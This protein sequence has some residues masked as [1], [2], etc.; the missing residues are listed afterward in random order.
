[1]I[2]GQSD[3]HLDEKEVK[4]LNILTDRVKKLR[5]EWEDA[6]PVVCPED[7][8]LFTKSW[9][10]TE[11]MPVDLRWAQAFKKRL[12]ESPVVIRDGELIVSSLT[13]HI[14][15][16]NLIAAFKPEQVLEMLED[17]R[18]ARTMS[19]TASAAID[20]TD[21]QLLKE[22]AKYWVEHMPPD[23]I[24]DKLR[25]ELGENHTEL[26]IDKGGILEG[27]FLKATQERGLF[28]DCGAW[29]GILCLHSPVID[30]GLNAIIE[31]ANAEM[32]KM[33]HEG[34]ISSTDASRKY[35]LLQSVVISCQAIIDWAKRYAELARTMAKKE[36]NTVR[37]K[38]L[39]KIAEI[40]DW[41]PANPP[42]SFWEAVQSVRF[43]HLAIRKEQPLRPENSVGRLDQILNRYYEKDFKNG[44]ISRQEAAELLGC[45]WLKIREV[46][47]LQTQPPKTRIAP[48]SNLPDVTIGGRDEH[49]RD[50]TNELSWIILEVMRQMKLSEPAVYIRY[51][52]GLSDEFLIYAL[53]CNRDLQ[54]GIPA[55]LNDEL[56]SARY[57][58]RG[59]APKDA[60]DWAASGCL[61]YHLE[62]A[63][64]GG[65]QMHLNQAKILELTLYDGFDPRTGKQLGPKTGDATKFT[66]FDQ[67][68]NAYYKQVDYFADEMRKDYFIRWSTDQEINFN[69]GLSCALLFEDSIQK[70]LPPSKGGCRYPVACTAWVGDRG[71]T[72]VADS[73]AAIKYLAFDNKKITMAELIEAMKSNWNGKEEIHEMCLKSPKYGNDDDY[74]DNIFNMIST[75]TQEILQSRP[76]PFTG[77]K[78]FLY[79]GAAAGHI[80]HGLVVGALPNGRK[81]GTSINDAGTSAMPGMDTQ[82]PTALIN[83]AT[84][85]PHAKEVVGIA[86]NMKFSKSIFNS[87]EKLKKL[88]VL[89]RVFFARG[90]WHI[91]FNVHSVAELL[92]AKVHPENWRNLMVRVGGY[93][94]YFVDLPASLQDEIIARTMHEI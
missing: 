45:F 2:G 54:G 69:S 65:G 59:V 79:K 48:G 92:D 32:A 27:P 23:Y 42:R 29:G 21:A 82:G 80:I 61:G 25:N 88:S 5:Q 47:I 17:G 66:S 75:K 33:S 10:E 68:C 89:L 94:A 30:C 14:K 74:V 63:E 81:A 55:F 49:G 52:T 28:Q 53:E 19:D 44:A 11:G 22:D 43:I 13:K 51:H 83:S 6:Q 84:K 26:F 18:F 15:G 76:D 20:E 39:E 41:V 9:K 16:V 37:R 57:I 34:D 60:T 40:C 64:H 90:G 93:S 1:M 62:T 91:Q 3:Q 4:K 24:N 70:G 73:L 77:A 56:G 85:V 72:D 50:V 87:K 8:I 35:N 46:E 31:R 67:I 58:A 86:H 36:A 12:M 38:E 7:S 78:P 71:I